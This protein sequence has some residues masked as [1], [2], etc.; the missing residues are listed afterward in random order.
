MSSPEWRPVTPH[1]PCPACSRP[2]WCAW[3]QAGWLKCERAMNV[4]MGM[5]L[6]RPI[7]NGALFRPLAIVEALGRRPRR[8]RTMRT[9]REAGVPRPSGPD[10]D[11]LALDY[12]GRVDEA[13]L[14]RLAGDLGISRDSLQRLRIG[15][16]GQAWAFPMTDV[17][18][19]VRGIRLRLTNGRKLAIRGG[20]EGLFIPVHLPQS[21]RLLIS[22]GPTDTAALLDLGFAAIGRPSCSGGSRL[23]IDFVRSGKPSSVVIVADADPPGQRGAAALA[24]MVALQ[25]SD[26]RVITPPQPFKDARAWVQ[27]GASQ[28]DVDALIGQATPHRLAVVVRRVGR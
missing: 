24:S 25:C 18:G 26:V 2:D 22:E 12:I 5:K 16:T 9:N 8:V 3:T 17:G 20:R 13:A 6:V 23:A 7:G 19:R 4:P 28:H 27:S 14:A 1:A 21:S 15:W 10:F 11:S